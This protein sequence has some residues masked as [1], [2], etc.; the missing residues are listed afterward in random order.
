MRTQFG[1]RIFTT[2]RSRIG[3]DQAISAPALCQELGWPESRERFVRRIIADESALWP[4]VLIC[5]VPGD[6]YFC[7]ATYEEAETYLNW[8]SALAAEAAN[9]VT[10]FRASAARQGLV[11]PPAPAAA[12]LLDPLPPLATAA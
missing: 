8:L 5:S 9:K 11:F 10:S 12:V 3:R 2:L 1:D 7:A 6:G 4:G